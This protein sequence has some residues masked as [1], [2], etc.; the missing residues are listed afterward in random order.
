[1]PFDKLKTARQLVQALRELRPPSLTTL[2]NQNGH[3]HATIHK[4]FTNQCREIQERFQ[5]YRATSIQKVH[6]AKIAEF[7]QIDYRSTSKGRTYL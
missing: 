6:A 4:H 1:L 5:E 2:E 3:H 7:R